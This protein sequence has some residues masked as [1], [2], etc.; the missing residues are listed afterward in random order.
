MDTRRADV[1]DEF[2]TRTFTEHASWFWRNINPRS[3][4]ANALALLWILAISRFVRWFMSQRQRQQ[5]LE[6]RQHEAQQ[7]LS[8]R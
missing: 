2:I 8:K 3:V 7:K 1:G 4:F 5:Q 6:M